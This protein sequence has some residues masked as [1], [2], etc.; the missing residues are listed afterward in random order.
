VFEPLALV[1]ALK[2]KYMAAETFALP[3]YSSKAYPSWLLPIIFPSHAE[4]NK[5]LSQI[6][7]VFLPP[8]LP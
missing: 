8:S 1:D 4:T 7:L 6:L 3:S 5:K 2:V